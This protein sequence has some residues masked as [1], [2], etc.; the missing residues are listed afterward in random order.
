[1]VSPGTRNGAFDLDFTDASGN[2][3]GDPYGSMA[4]LSV[5]VPN[6]ISSGSDAGDVKVLVQ[7]LQLEQFDTT[8][9]VAGRFVH[10]Q[11]GVG[12]AGRAAAE[13]VADDRRLDLV[14][15]AAAAAYCGGDDRDDGSVRERCTDAAVPMQSG[16]GQPESAAEVVKGIRL[17]SSLMLAMGRGGLL[18]LRVENT[19]ALQQPNRCR[20][21]PT[22]RSS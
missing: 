4:Y 10:E 7:G 9:G 15:F 2:P 18:T 5:V 17:G 20:T 8:R 3:L 22:A 13:R 6:R 21:G 14:S 12:V 16:A 11:S 1:M 19:L